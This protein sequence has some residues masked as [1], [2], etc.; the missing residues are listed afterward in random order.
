MWSNY[1]FWGREW[2]FTING[3]KKVNNSTKVPQNIRLFSV[4]WSEI[5]LSSC[6]RKALCTQWHACVCWCYM[7]YMRCGTYFMKSAFMSECYLLHHIMKF[8][9]W[10]PLLIII[11]SSPLLLSPWSGFSCHA[12]E[13]Q[14]EKVSQLYTCGLQ[15]N[16][17]LLKRVNVH[18][19]SFL[20]W[21]ALSY[22]TAAPLMNS[23]KKQFSLQWF[24]PSVICGI[25]P[26][27]AT[28]THFCS[29]RSWKANRSI[30]REQLAR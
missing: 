10:R 1:W 9:V 12:H 27:S 3:F 14:I 5:R 29:V 13:H 28:P 30:W 25:H 4:F 23:L 26:L 18:L 24:T 11:I 19:P 8:L 2:S 22:I 16:F 21:P 6:E 20:Q 7:S 15:E 17:P